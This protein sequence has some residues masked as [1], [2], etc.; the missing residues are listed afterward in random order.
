MRAHMKLG[1]A[2]IVSSWFVLAG[3]SGA[4]AQ[5]TPAPAPSDPFFDDTVIHEIRL[6]INTKDW[7]TL[8]TNFLLNDYYPCDFKWG[9]TTVRNVGIRSRGTGSRS[10]VKPGLRVDF[11]RY[12]TNQKFLGLKSF[13]LR[14]Q[15]QDSSGIHERVAML[16]FRRQG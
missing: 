6:A 5:T 11:D 14:N 9:S 8:K 3:A 13:V 1:F 10:G 4:A 12:T 7:S 15:T 2:L 16:F